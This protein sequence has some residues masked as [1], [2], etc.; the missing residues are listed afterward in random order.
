[1]KHKWLP[2]IALIL[3]GAFAHHA[4]LA[5]ELITVRVGAM[6]FQVEIADTAEKRRRGLMFRS[7]LAEDH[8]M[9]FLQEPSPA[10]F[11]M[12]NTYIALDLLFFDAEQRLVQI[13]S[14]VPPCRTPHCPTYSSSANNIRYILEINAG[15]AA[16]HGIKVGAIL[17]LQADAQ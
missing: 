4:L 14:A 5:A 17:H 7:T 15:A 2:H 11:W 9:L 1:M 6:P 12:K 10:M 8:G 16:K 3:L 13:I